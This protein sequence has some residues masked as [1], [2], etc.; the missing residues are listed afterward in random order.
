MPVSVL[1]T[2]PAM[3]LPFAVAVKEIAQRMITKRS[4]FIGI[5]IR[6]TYST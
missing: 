1:Y 4:G 3:F 2:K 6:K 5:V